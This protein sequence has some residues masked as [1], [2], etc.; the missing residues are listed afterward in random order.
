M[1][2]IVEQLVECKLAGEAEVLGENL[3]QRHFVHHKSHIT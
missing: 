3:R 2:V 1:M